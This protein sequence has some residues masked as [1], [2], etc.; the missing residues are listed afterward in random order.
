MRTTYS[1]SVPVD[2]TRIQ[3]S[4]LLTSEYKHL[5]TLGLCPFQCCGERLTFS[6]NFLASKGL[7]ELD[8]IVLAFETNSGLEEGPY[9]EG[10]FGE[11]ISQHPGTEQKAGPLVYRGMVF[12]ANEQ[13]LMA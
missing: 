5:P 6:C 13:V 7:P 12:A 4:A 3:H 8:E 2:L 9:F 11:H 10:Y 1:P